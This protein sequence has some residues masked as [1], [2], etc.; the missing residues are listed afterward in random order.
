MMDA[1]G[2]SEQEFQTLKAGWI[3]DLE[4]GCPL[5]SLCLGLF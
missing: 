1:V 5:V 4:R 2:I 3:Y